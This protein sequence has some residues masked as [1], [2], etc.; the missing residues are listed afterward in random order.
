MT[1]VVAVRAAGLVLA[2][3]FLLGLL[4]GS[5]AAVAI[6]LLALA[7]GRMVAVPAERL[8][9]AAAVIV[10]AA[11][12]A[13][14]AARWGSFDLDFL[15]G[16]QAVLGPTVAVAPAEAAGA[17]VAAAAAGTV[18]LGLWLGRPHPLELWGLEAIAGALI[19]VTVFAGAAL[20]GLGAPGSFPRLVLWVA[21]SAAIAAAA[22][23]VA[24]W[25]Y[26]RTS[27]FRWRLLAAAGIVTTAAGTVLASVV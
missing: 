23:A 26:V 18:A 19:L 15:R 16:A 10:F 11:A 14:G 22:G 20:P 4:P 7:A 27:K 3:P 8:F 25:A 9:T 13:V 17:A 24:T 1:P 12:T 6:G 5:L 21:G 2:L